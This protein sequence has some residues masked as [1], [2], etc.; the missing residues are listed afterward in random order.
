MPNKNYISG[1]RR[2]RQIVNEARKKGLIAFRSAGSHSPI[3]CV[4]IDISTRKIQLI[5]VKNKKVYGK[6]KKKIDDLTN[7]SDEYFVEFMNWT[8]DDLIDKRKKEHK[9]QTHKHL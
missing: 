4:V 8:I 7:Y 5:Q 1:V 9:Q 3:D 6:E 2:E